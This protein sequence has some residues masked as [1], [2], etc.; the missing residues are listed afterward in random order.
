L[1]L[2]AGLRVVGLTVF[3][4]L[5]L[6]CL[7]VG[8]LW[9]FAE[10]APGGE[11]IRRLATAQ[12][13]R[14]IA[15]Q[16]AV[17][18]LRFG[19][20]RLTL[21]DVVVRDP[22]GVAVG[23][24]GTVD[25]E[26]SPWAL[27]RRR[28]EVRRISLRR[29]ELRLALDARGS[30]LGRAFAP[31]HPAPARP[32]APPTG[33]AAGPNLV[34][35]VAAL[36][37]SG[38]A[39]TV[40]PGAPE[41]HVAAIDA[42]GSARYDGR[43]GALRADLRVVTEAGRVEVHGDLD[44]SRGRPG[45]A[46]LAAHAREI[47][48]GALMRDLP[49]TNLALDLQARGDQVTADLDAAA[50]GATVRGRGSLDA[51]QVEARL[52]IEA[53]DLAATGRSLARCHLAPPLVLAGHGRIDVAVS[54]PRDRPSLRVA[55]RIPRLQVGQDRVRDLTVSATLPRLDAPTAVDLD[56]TA[57]EAR[58][59]GH[60]LGGLSA[61][62]RASGR[63]VQADV[64]VASPTPLALDASGRRLS[65]RTVEIERLAL[66]TTEA[67]WSLARPTR[68][69]VGGGRLALAGLDLR[70]GEQVIAADLEKTGRRGHVRLHVA[71]LDPG[72]LPRLLVP[73]AAATVG[74]VDVDL[75]LAFGP[76]RAA[77]RLAARALHSGLDATFD[78]PLA[79][80]PRR[81]RAPAKLKLVTEEIDVAT[82][83]AAV[84]RLTGKPWP[85]DPRGKLRLTATV[86]GD[87]AHPRVSL[88]VG[89]R[90]LVLAGRSLGDLALDLGGDDDRPLT[91]RLRATRQGRPPATLTAST[92]LTLRALLQRRQTREALLRTPFE[93]EGQIDRAPLAVLG[94]LA[95][96]PALHGGTIS[97]QL[98]ARG[99]ARDPSGTLTADLVG[100]TADR[101][102]A[103]DARVELTLDRRATV[104]H[105]RVVR[106]GHPVL[107]LE[108]RLGADASALADRARLVDAP[109]SLRAV[110]GPL[111]MR[112]LGLPAAVTGGARE[113]V[114]RG[115]LHADLSVDGT[116]RAPRAVAHVQAGDVRLDQA[117]VGYANLEAHYADR[118]ARV[119]LQGASANGGTLALHAGAEIDLGV[120]ALRARPID[121]L[122]LPFELR[123]AA[124]KLDLRAFSGLTPAVR[125]VGGLLDAQVTAHGTLRDPRFSGRVDCARCE[126]QL[127]G[128]GEFREVRLALHGDT[129]KVVLEE[130]S[131]KNGEGDGRLTGSLT[132]DSQTNSYQV[133]GKIVV[134]EIPVYQEGQP[135]AHVSLDAALSGT[136]GGRGSDADVKVAIHDAHLKLS[137]EKRR[138]LQSMRTPDDVVVVD[139][140]QPVDRAQARKLRALAVRAHAAGAPAEATPGPPPESRFWKRIK[141]NLE[142]PR[143]LWVNGGGANLELGLDPGF[144]IVL[145]RETRI[146]G[147][148][149][150]RR[151][152]VD[153]L[154]RF[155][156]KADSTLT[157]EGAPE[158]PTLDATAQY[159]DN[160]DNVTVQ[161][162]AKGPID[163]LSISV[164][165][166]NRPDLTEAQ[167]Y[168]LIIT[169][170]L[171]GSGETGSGG[172]GA[173]ASNEATS[174]VAG[175]IAGQLQKTLSEHLPLDVLTIDTGSGQGFSGTQLEAGRYVTDRLYVGYV[176][177]V[178]ADPTRYQ[179]KN[180]VHIEYQ[181]TSR[182]QVAGEYGDV[183]TGSADLMWRKNY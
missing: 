58:L 53:D 130:L 19:G 139:G 110:V 175:A 177:R 132:R 36:S 47:D 165:S 155:D 6:V 104:A 7:T 102:P 126:A 16:V 26:F 179:N 140:G 142:A 131:A 21:D 88:Q 62:V 136:S 67:T 1:R 8:G 147:Q 35:D 23:S 164:S 163:H 108:A 82:V 65:P 69:T 83:A 101:V 180:A 76:T 100:L 9:T 52:R 123:I 13:N 138:K 30:N 105:V 54:G 31:A 15:G 3:A 167:L 135:L 109:V 152:R 74:P 143:Q 91:L 118:K 113:A 93:V 97:V 22:A 125:R 99:S 172:L 111:A 173:T 71:R 77:G 66:R 63:R 44:L 29:P 114:L 176:G 78:L 133:A 112:R 98:S 124:E 14:R 5:A 106:L 20:D 79:W 162:V 92:P 103:T 33:S 174:L 12:I 89:G 94:K 141:V 38:G 161:V 183:G 27:L 127:A 57:A 24:I 158:R 166:T 86:D 28:I 81:G 75:D 178:G 32:A 153:V 170:H 84:G 115:Q 45:P 169:G 128:V 159:Q 107:A 122:R 56:L 34:V 10:T 148:V 2:R 116:L 64:R 41:V 157:F 146:Y 46:G 42:D 150:V 80:P 145:A 90:A 68:L 95:G 17:G 4:V 149:I 59:G 73:R 51:G 39:L 61:T 156:L 119:D 121:P 40:R 25:V 70:S 18:R 55:G 120:L 160:Q 134:K 117:P 154:R 182:W 43:A 48:L 50:P 49:T 168:T 87:V 181:L 96:V 137:D 11:V 72:R 151:G 60:A 37:V 144:H 129:D 171:P 85:Y